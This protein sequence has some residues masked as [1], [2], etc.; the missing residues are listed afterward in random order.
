MGVPIGEAQSLLTIMEIKGL[1]EEEF[2]QIKR[3]S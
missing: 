2:G 1:I 3:K